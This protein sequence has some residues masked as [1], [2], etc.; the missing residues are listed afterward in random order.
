MLT[1]YTVSIV[2]TVLSAMTSFT[3]STPVLDTL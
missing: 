3:G 1:F 2:V